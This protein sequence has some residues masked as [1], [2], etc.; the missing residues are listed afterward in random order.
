[1]A[2]RGKNK[3]S[4]PRN[5]VLLLIVIVIVIS[6][7]LL[8]APISLPFLSE[9]VSRLI[10]NSNLDIK[11]GGLTLDF[12]QSSGSYVVFEDTL[13]EVSGEASARVL[14]PKVRAK[15][16]TLGLFLGRIEVNS[17]V[18]SR[19][20]TL[21]RINSSSAPLPKVQTEVMAMDKF[22]TIIA[23]ELERW[24]LSTITLE[25]GFLNISAAG[26]TYLASGIDAEFKLLD[27]L[28]FRVNANV[29][30]RL[31]RWSWELDRL[32]DVKTGER[33]INVA[34]KNA[35]LGDLLSLST[36]K[37][38][39]HLTSTRVTAV[40]KGYLGASG[41]FVKANFDIKTSE[42]FL[43]SAEEDIRLDSAHLNT[44]VVR[45]DD[46]LTINQL[47]L[48]SG[49][50]RLVLGGSISPPVIE[51]APW[52]YSLGSREIV[53]APSDV[54]AKPL[55]FY[56]A[57]LNGRVNTNS[58]TVFIDYAKGE[59]YDSQIL[60]A[61]SLDYGVH[62]PALALAVS[63]P[64]LSLAQVMQVWPV[65]AAHKA[66]DWLTEH[67]KGG[68]ASDIKLDLALGPHAFD[69]VVGGE[70]GWSG[71]DITASFQ[72]HDVALKPL[73]SLPEA[74]ELNGTGAIKGESLDIVAN[75]G[76]FQM[77]DGNK[78]SVPLVNFKIHDLAEND[79][80][81]TDLLIK[82]KGS[83]RDLAVLLDSEP[84]NALDQL[85]V[86]P[87][88]F[89]GKGELELDAELALAEDIAIDDIK[90][91]AELRTSKFSSTSKISGQELKNAD[92]IIQANQDEIAITGKGE[93]NGLQADIKM[94]SPLDK[95]DREAATQDIVLEADA[96]E[97]SKQAPGIDEFLEG[98]VKIRVNDTDKGEFYELDLT[99][100]KIKLEPIGWTKAPGVRAKA[101]MQIKKK[102]KATV[103]D[104]FTL[105]S[106]GVDI[107]GRLTINA[108]GQFQ[109][110]EFKRFN[111]RPS[112]S[113]SLSVKVL[114]KNSLGI[115]ANGRSFD[116]RSI[117]RQLLQ[118]TG[119]KNGGRSGTLRLNAQIK[120]VTG[121]NG[122]YVSDVNLKAN[123]H[124]KQIQNLTFN[125]RTQ[126]RG[127]I[128]VKLEPF[129]GA[130][131]V[132]GTMDSTGD[133]LRFLDLF[134]RMQ[135]GRGY[136]NII[137]P[138]QSNWVGDFIVKDFS[139]ID[140]KAIRALKNVPK[141]K[142][143]RLKN[144]AVY[145]DAVKNGEATFN[146]M[147]INFIR[148][149]NTIDITRGRLVGTVLG[150]FVSGT[151]DL[152]SKRLNMT[153]TFV[154]AYAINNLFAKIPIIGFALG[155]SSDGGLIGVTYKLTGTFTDPV[156]KINP[157]SAIAPG[158]F[159]KIFEY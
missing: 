52:S 80:N 63:S 16:N 31:G 128:A 6:A 94:K 29:A 61:G 4:W 113:M 70:A 117:I 86:E 27:D 28:S 91:K 96:K 114:G 55:V 124:N 53:L 38:V 9:Y 105:V 81:P 46:D 85:K 129:E 35:A 142:R 10:T 107:Q 5:T 140:D 118:N 67:I 123:V 92:L 41:D 136:L 65:P 7:R 40:G 135:A 159:R 121:F 99:R 145:R 158:I 154:P 106:D 51:G 12:S 57:K 72:L 153:G 13:V 90:W 23:S 34:I 101:S 45:G 111:L 131:R 62:G 139:I 37:E 104:R 24:E 54:E 155:G 26:Q 36:A 109:E 102:G 126:D 98:P 137:M 47:I 14:L 125:G 95:N 59:S 112:D 88:A 77:P 1:M 19:P 156:F 150:G 120:Q 68:R 82:V 3:R 143:D 30:G 48:R 130:Q 15:I 93:L 83:A 49:E 97:L 149:R 66:R 71:D 18:I 32:V 78:L 42:L 64:G 58:K 8:Y 76:F 21:L 110:A 2:I 39:P 144:A 108:K 146:R 133:V 138:D 127:Q 148:S 141:N 103:I 60:I 11:I 115:R 119:N 152:K 44:S 122:V 87:S 132:T 22:S 50:T 79:P 147:E 151:A 17:L 89:S 134:D 43:G 84:I 56:R 116:A 73:P 157:V 69:G 75:S 100:S 33:L 20:S 25:R 74:Q